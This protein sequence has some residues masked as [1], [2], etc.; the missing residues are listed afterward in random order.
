VL[1]HGNFDP[2]EEET[3]AVDDEV[4]KRFEAL[5]DPEQRTAFYNKHRDEIQRGF[6]ARKNNKS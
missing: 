2:K 3:V 5:T 1:A 4:L 6:E